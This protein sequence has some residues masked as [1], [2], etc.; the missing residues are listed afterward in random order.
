MKNKLLLL[1]FV[2][3]S[4]ACQENGVLSEEQNNRNSGQTH[5]SNAANSKAGKT[6][7]QKTSNKAASPA[8]N[9]GRETPKSST[10]TAQEL[11]QLLENDFGDF[12][13]IDS[14]QPFY[15]QGDF[16]GDGNRDIAFVIGA[17]DRYA[18]EGTPGDIV[19][20]LCRAGADASIQNLRTNVFLPARPRQ[21]CSV[22]E[23]KKKALQTKYSPFGLLLALG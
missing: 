18:E 13:L 7:E 4:T 11:R 14:S 2:L 5:S 6:S 1:V 22:V 12:L 10:V 19:D 3:I 8:Q 16:N 23:S 17:Q 15:V 21:D 20:N 9:H